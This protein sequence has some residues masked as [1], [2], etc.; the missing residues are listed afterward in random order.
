MNRRR[1]LAA[2]A[3]TGMGG[4]LGW[5]GLMEPRMVRYSRHGAGPGPRLVQISD[6]HLGSLGGVHEGIAREVGGLGADVILLTGDS[7]E[8]PGGLDALSAFLALLPPAPVL[9]VMGNWEYWGGVSSDS[10]GRI[11]S[12]T[13]GRLLVNESDLVATRAGEVLFTGLDDLVAG[14]PDTGE[15]LRGV[16]PAPIHVVL[17]HCPAQRDRLDAELAGTAYHP[18]L[19]L[20]GHTHGGQVD[21]LGLRLTPRGSGPYVEGWYQDGGPP[22]YVSRG[23]GTSVVPLRIGA[24]PEVAVFDLGGPDGPSTVLA[25]DTDDLDVESVRAYEDETGG[26]DRA[27]NPAREG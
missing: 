14:R 4:L 10:L 24:P 2:T 18:S 26:T 12:R 7:V 11:L 20:S 23:I 5:G 21:V 9:A 22:L 6:L 1:F 27:L 17:A 8:E 25:T 15:A 3:T 16:T 19:V 13:D